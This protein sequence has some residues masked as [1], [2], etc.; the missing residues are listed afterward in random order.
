M[1]TAKDFQ[2]ESMDSTIW[3]NIRKKGVLIFTIAIYGMAIGGAIVIAGYGIFVLCQFIEFI[4][5]IRKALGIP[6]HESGPDWIVLGLII[7]VICAMLAIFIT[8]L[9]RYNGIWDKRLREVWPTSEERIKHS[10]MHARKNDNVFLQAQY[11][12]ELLKSP[13]WREQWEDVCSSIPS[14][15]PGIKIVNPDILSDVEC[16]AAAAG[17]AAVVRRRIAGRALAVALV[18][19]FSRK[20]WVDQL[21]ICIAGFEI[22]LEVLGMLGKRPTLKYWR[23]MFKRT[24]A[25]IFINSYFNQT[26]MS[27]LT[28][29]IKGVAMGVTAALEAADEM[30]D[31]SDAPVEEVFD[32]LRS[33]LGNS[34]GGPFLGDFLALL[35]KGAAISLIGLDL[36]LSA[37]ASA[38]RTLA[39]II[40]KIGDDILEA[41]LAGGV[42]YY[43]GVELMRET[44]PFDDEQADSSEFNPSPYDCAVEMAK[45]GG[46][47]LLDLVRKRRRQF[48]QRRNAAAKSLASK[49]PILGKIFKDTNTN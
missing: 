13:K 22:Q 23:I 1:D 7:L 18:T 30:V 16:R 3:G 34:G 48:V 43:H 12:R 46:L 24:L 36:G 31:A 19:G 47:A 45:S 4:A 33:L 9:R 37:G 44:L 2:Q 28:L 10:K 41:S 39:G 14:R 25:S 11:I 8:V 49:A 26:Q 38:S 42:L 35:E 40:E 20:R 29:T 21:A 5:R 6:V 27:E 17:I 32:S 15:Y